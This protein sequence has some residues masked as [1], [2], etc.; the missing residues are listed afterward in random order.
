MGKNLEGSDPNLIGMLTSIETATVKAEI[1]TEHLP[2]TSL[3][4]YS[5][6]NLPE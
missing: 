2:V 6:T 3:K 4:R 5:Y 1:R